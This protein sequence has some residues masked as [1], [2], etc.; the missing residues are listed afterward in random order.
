MY[1]YYNEKFI[2]FGLSIDKDSVNNT[3]FVDN[4]KQFFSSVD[5]IVCALDLYD[6]IYVDQS[7]FGLALEQMKGCLKY[8]EAA[9]GLV[10]NELGESLMIFRLGKWDLPK[11]KI[12][13]GESSGECSLREVEEECGVNGLA[14]GDKI[15]DTYHIYNMYDQWVVKKT[16]WYNMSCPQ[17]QEFKPQVEED[18]SQV[19]WV[20]EHEISEKLNNT[21]P[22]VVEVFEKAN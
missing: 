1:I 6:A 14:L 19:C 17:K 7:A 15:C 10:R 4:P 11:G 20:K 5:N 9:G 22:S 3:M 16:F 8:I 2:N 12:E 21:Y 13:I 18:I